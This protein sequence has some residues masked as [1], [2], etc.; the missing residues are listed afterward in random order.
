MWMIHSSN[1][2]VPNGME[3]TSVPDI[4]LHGRSGGSAPVAIM[5]LIWFWWDSSARFTHAQIF[6]GSSIVQNQATKSFT[7]AHACFVPLLIIFGKIKI[8]LWSHLF[9]WALQL[10][11]WT[12]TK[13]SLLSSMPCKL[14]S[15]KSPFS[16]FQVLWLI[17]SKESGNRR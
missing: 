17:E 10:T 6:F 5:D 9:P 2:S 11:P 7:R 12:I 15:E 3:V 4:D 1:C 16:L 8:G 14:G 13:L